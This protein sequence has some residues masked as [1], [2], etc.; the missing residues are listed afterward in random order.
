MDN[1][2][3]M[4][5]WLEV[6]AEGDFDAFPGTVSPDF[7]LHLPFVPPGVPSEMH[8]RE[9]VRERLAQTAKGRTPLVFSDVVIMRTEDPDL[10]MTRCKGE[11]TM[12]NGKTYR[13]SY[14]MLTRIRDG[15]VLEHT[16]YLNPLAV[17]AAFDDPPEQS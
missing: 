14:V 13:N 8:G 1:V 5:A 2:E 6:F 3:L 7:T 16:E 11:A 12:A 17:I 9:V 10:V 4:K 15:E